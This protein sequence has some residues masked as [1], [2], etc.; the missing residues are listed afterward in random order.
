MLMIAI[1]TANSIILKRVV[2]HISAT[3]GTAIAPRTGG[4][5]DGSNIQIFNFN[6]ED[7]AWQLANGAELSLRKRVVRHPLPGQG[8]AQSAATPC[9]PGP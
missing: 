9:T 6:C 3:L 4:G 5:P 7:M 1:H 8:V 2:R